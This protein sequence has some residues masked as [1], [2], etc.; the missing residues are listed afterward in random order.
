MMQRLECVCKNPLVEKNSFLKETWKRA[1][2]PCFK[3]VRQLLPQP[4]WDGHPS[5]LDCYW[6]CWQ[7][8]FENLRRP[9][10]QNRFIHNY[11]DTAFNGNLFMW[12]SVFILM[13]GRYG[14]RAFNFQQTLDNLYAHQLDDGFISREI[15]PD[16]QARFHRHDPSS[17]GPNVLAWSEWE[18]FLNF[19]GVER[20]MRI[21][22]V[23]LAYHQ[24]TKR[25][26]TWQDG[27]YWS[28]GWGC[29][30]DNQ[31]RLPAGCNVHWEN[32]HMSWIDATAQA[33]LSA[34]MLQKIAA[35][36]K[37]REGVKEL[38]SES[39]ALARLINTH[40]WNHKQLFYCDRFRDGRVSDIKTIGAFWMLLAGGIPA[41]RR[42]ALIAHLDNKRQFNRPHRVPSLSADDPQ[43]DKTFGRYWRGSVW[44]STNYMV[45]RGLTSIGDDD[46]AHAIAANHHDNVVRVFE[47]TGT[48]WEN[49][50]A[51]QALPGRPAKPDFVGWG[52]L[53]PIAVFLEYLIGLRSCASENRLVWDVRLT[54]AHGVDAY[55]FGAEG[56]MNLRCQARKSTSE[57]PAVT[58]ESNIPV[59]VE[60]RWNGGKRLIET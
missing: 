4:F 57:K 23:L 9:T 10:P 38:S 50:A 46:L 53:G 1:S 18:Y 6:K 55:P 59:T 37:E 51:E 45:L 47:E 24:W 5:A 2:L 15:M 56:R 28:S 41:H 39:R 25:Y 14:S 60:L 43:Y 40:M 33:L 27:S 21:Y 8:A 16:G 26:R 52:G 29:G 11:I 19:G 7:L 20:L 36:I 44:P 22:P 35:A 54:E 42:K 3:K 32:G 30:M 13:F 58:I 34:K 48:V 12:D 31:P 17:T 49:Y